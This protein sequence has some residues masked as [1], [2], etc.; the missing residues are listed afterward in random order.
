[1][2]TLSREAVERM[3]ENDGWY[4]L[5]D[6]DAPDNPRA[7]CL[8]RYFNKEFEK[9]DWAVA[10]H[11]GQYVSY[12]ASPAVGEIEVLWPKAWAGRYNHG[13]GGMSYERREQ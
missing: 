11:P 7:W 6:T 3:I 1:M 4:D 2:P 9:I 12:L 5:E 13:E 10:Y 8:L